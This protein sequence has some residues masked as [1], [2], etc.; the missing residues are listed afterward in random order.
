MKPD[1]KKNNQKKRN[2]TKSAKNKRGKT[3]GINLS[4]KKQL[5]PVN[6]KLQILVGFV[7]PILIVIAVGFSSYRQAADGLIETYE[8]SNITSMEMASQLIDFGLQSIISSSSEISTDSNF[9]TY[10]SRSSDLNS[11]RA[12]NDMKS[13]ILLKQLSNDFVKNIHLIPESPSAVLSSASIGSFTGDEIYGDIR[14]EMENQCSSS[15]SQEKWGSNHVQLDELFKLDPEEYAGSFCLVGNYKRTMII[16]DINASRIRSVLSE[17]DLGQGSV[18]GYHTKEG[19]EILVGSDDFTFSDKEYAQ[20]A[21][22]SQEV[23]GKNY[24]TVNGREYLYMYRRCNTND[25]VISALVPKSVITAQALTIRHTVIISI[26]ISCLVVGVIGLLILLGLQRNLKLITEGLM[27]ASQGDLT[28]DFA[29]GGKSEFAVLSKHVMDTL[30]NTKNLISSV[31]NTTQDV[32]LSSNNVGKV[33]DVINTSVAAISDAIAEI[34]NGVNQEANEA[35]E[36]LSK[37]DALSGK[38]LRTGDKIL[39]VEQL[40]DSTKQ[41]VQDGSNSMEQLIEQSHETFDITA[42]VNEKVDKL[43]EHSIQIEEFVNN[44]NDIADQTTLLSLNASIEAARAGQMGRGFTVVAEEIKKLSE[45]SMESAKAI[46]DLVRQIHVMTDDA[47]TATSQAQ[48]IVKNQQEMVETTK[49]MFL[50]MNEVIEHLLDN[51]KQV[52]GEIASMD[53]DR[54]DTL[55][56]IK[57]ISDVIEETL[58]STHQVSERIK[59][60]ASIMNG[61][62]DATHQLNDNTTELNHAVSKFQ[63]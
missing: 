37:M 59:E 3:L 35:E 53:I 51:M 28:V 41:M 61:L 19:K 48:G 11:L 52:A 36:C 10:A 60:Q 4:R 50:D 42:T 23:S 56:S 1:K 9:L 27:K 58:A 20:N 26:I 12:K 44:I 45:N 33:S 13:T 43:I 57:N 31:Q 46:E 38:I 47:K 54:A 5:K 40:A 49:Q 14:S 2:L 30:G 62:T 21:Y 29:M 32:S 7:I 22:S 63:L 16:V 25:A 17:I 34:N 8:N 6:L 15:K 18:I 39:E 55:N 24:V